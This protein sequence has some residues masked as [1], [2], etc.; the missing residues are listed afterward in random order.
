M[1]TA[2]ELTARLRADLTAAM[3]RRDQPAVRAI[4][5]LMAA[6]A[7]AE[8]PP[9]DAAPLEVRGELR[10]HARRELTAEDLA[11][12]VAEQIADRTDTIATYRANGRD[13]AADELQR[14]IDVLNTYQADT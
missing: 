11:A 12:I 3:R 5:T 2:E 9:I 8:A 7:N 6:V 1:S 14:E 4:R 13:D 10:Q